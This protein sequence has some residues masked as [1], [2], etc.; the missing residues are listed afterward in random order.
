MSKKNTDFLPFLCLALIWLTVLCV[1]NS[2]C[3][4][5]CR[6]MWSC[7]TATQARLEERSDTCFCSEARWSSLKGRKA[8]SHLSSRLLSSRAQWR[9]ADFSER[10]LCL[11]GLLFLCPT[12][13]L[14]NSYFFNISFHELLNCREAGIAQW[15]EHWTHDWKVAGLNTCRSGGRIFFSRVDFLCWPLF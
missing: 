15:L 2:C 13:V 6:M 1:T 4:D 10:C 12:C 14:I 3:F 8:T 7:G 11:K 5:G 9:W